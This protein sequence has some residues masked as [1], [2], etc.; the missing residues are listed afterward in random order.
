VTRARAIAAA[1]ALP[2]ASLTLWDVAAFG[3]AQR[4]A[5]EALI[6]RFIAKLTT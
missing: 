5:I 1:R 4:R 6:M 3:G 2:S